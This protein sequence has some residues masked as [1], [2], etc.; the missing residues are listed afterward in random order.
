MNFTHT[1][2][3]RML[4]DSLER[5]LAAQHPIATR[6][7]IVQSALGH[8]P[9][10][11]AQ[12]VELG[13]I[14]AL[15]DEAHGGFGGTGHDIA[16]VF[17]SLGRSLV[18]EPVLAS[19]V[20]AGSALV[21]ALQGAPNE[22]HLA[23]LKAIIEGRTIATLALDEA[24]SHYELQRVATRAQAHDG[25]YVL[26]GVKVVVPN[27]AQASV[28]IVSAR[29]SG[30]EADVAHP[31]G[32]SLFVLPLDTPGVQVEGHT[33]VD[34]TR[35][36]TVRLKDVRLPAA[37]LLGPAGQGLSTIEHAV[38]RGIVALC[39]ESLG[40][41][42]VAKQHTIEYLQ[43]RKQFGKPIGSFQA[44]QHRMAD[45]LLEIEQARSAVI[46]AAEALSADRITREKALSAAK[47]SIGR[48]G[49]LVAEACIQLHGGI[50]MTWELPMPHYAKRLVMI[51]HQLGDEDHHLARF[52]ALG[53]A[54]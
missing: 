5:Y 48:I 29:T 53:E 44:L 36:A 20:L 52:I 49:N 42:E 28:A 12:L 15:F 19:A 4:A 47:Y 13:V 33:H 54:A 45:V 1:E 25:A 10:H 9:Q 32:I 24:Q 41:M 46:N 34:G 23:L 51:D 8:S 50:G 22:A 43:T 40:A 3:R 18:V 30:D 7:A 6:H 2:D 27:G 14:G 11:W 17:E 31:Q 38:G 35:S 39:A 16:V 37:A 21:H 26:N